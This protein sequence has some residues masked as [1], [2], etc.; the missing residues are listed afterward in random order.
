M[1]TIRF[2]TCV[3]SV[4]GHR[5]V[6]VETGRHYLDAS[7]GQ[8]LC[9]ISDFIDQYILGS[10]VA[11]DGRVR[12][13]DNCISDGGEERA[14]MGY[15][16]QHELLQQIPELKRDVVIPDVCCILLD[17]EDDDGHEEVIEQV[18]FGPVGT[19]SPAH[20]DPYH[21]VLVQITGTSSLDNAEE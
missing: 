21:N 7:S 2:H 10:S 11:R 9:T 12:T 20:H 15:L 8:R 18:W 1:G 13:S 4:A 14:T 17:E 6:P 16:A 19:I 5:T 3:Y